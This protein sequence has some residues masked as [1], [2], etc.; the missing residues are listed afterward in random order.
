MIIIGTFAI[1]HRGYLEILDKYPQADIF[2]LSDELANQLYKLEIDLRKMPLEKVKSLLTSLNRRIFTLDFNNIENI[3]NSNQIVLINDDVINELKNR[4]FNNHPNLIIET[5]FY[6]HPAEKVAR[7]QNNSIN[8][9]KNYTEIDERYM[10][11][12]IILAA[13]SG[14]FWRQIACLVVKDGKILYQS[15]NRMLPNNDECYKI[16][17]IRDNLK[18]G[19]KTAELCSATHSEANCIAQAARDGVSLKGT[20]IYVT[21]FPCP[22]CAKLIATS[23]ITKCYYNQGWA[24]FDGERVMKAAGVQLIKIDL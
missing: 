10:K 9:L 13:E 15:Y 17:C 3:K 18:P 6:Y 11:Q 22:M 14:C 4:Y 8:I 23:G 5:G 16:G 12:A 21:T 19:E 20:S 1:I 2:I 24:N 7:A